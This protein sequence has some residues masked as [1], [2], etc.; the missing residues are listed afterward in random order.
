MTFEVA[1]VIIMLSSIRYVRVQDMSKSLVFNAILY[2]ATF[3]NQRINYL[4]KKPFINVVVFYLGNKRRNRFFPI[5]I[6][7][8]QRQYL[9]PHV[10]YLSLLLNQCLLQHFLNIREQ[11]FGIF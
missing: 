2:V 1:K 9:E 6:F 5:I 8:G 3:L 7:F 11:R 4:S 10:V